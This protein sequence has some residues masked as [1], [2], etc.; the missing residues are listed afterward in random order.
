[1]TTMARDPAA[2]DDKWEKISKSYLRMVGETTIAAAKVLLR[3]ANEL[4]PFSRA[5][6]ILDNGCGPGPVMSQLLSEYG[7]QIDQSC[8]LQATDFSPAMMNQVQAC[9]DHQMEPGNAIWQ[10]LQLSVQDAQAMEGISDNS[11]SHVVS[12]FLYMLLPNP[13]T[14]LRATRRIL[15]EDGLLALTCWKET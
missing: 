7:A 13:M 12:G 9:K 8:K 15:R 10:R 6:Y 11:V 14:A 4:L 3:S 5:T 2:I 1:M